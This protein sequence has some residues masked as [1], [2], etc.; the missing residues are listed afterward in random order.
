MARTETNDVTTY[1]AHGAESNSYNLPPP[2]TAIECTIKRVLTSTAVLAS[3]MPI[4]LRY[5]AVYFY[6]YNTPIH[7]AAN[8]IK[9][10][11]FSLKITYSCLNQHFSSQINRFH[12]NNTT[13]HY[14][15]NNAS[16]HALPFEA[17]T[18]MHCSITYGV[19]YNQPVLLPSPVSPMSNLVIIN[20]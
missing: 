7:K 11:T 1:P 3:R 12:P 16:A 4:Q 15:V 10:T 8:N 18:P 20:V 14:I 6:S 19:C 5:L 9:L 2:D 13:R 17:G